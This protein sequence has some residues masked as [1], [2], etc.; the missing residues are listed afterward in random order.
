MMYDDHLSYADYLIAQIDEI[1]IEASLWRH[2]GEMG[3]DD[4]REA[5]RRI[6]RLKIAGTYD[7][8]RKRL[9]DLVPSTGIAQPSQKWLQYAERASQVWENFKAGLNSPDP[10]QQKRFRAL[11]ETESMGEKSLGEVVHI[12]SVLEPARRR[13]KRPNAIPP[14]RNVFE[15]LDTMRLE[16]AS[17]ETIAQAARSVA[18]TGGSDLEN[19]RA[20]YLA[21]LYSDRVALRG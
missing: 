14:W 8:E 19:H 7:N 18:A 6:D 13:G 4:E 16:I 1:E 21:R 9:A 12:L 10:D 15:Q 20:D 5:L 11:Y 2:P 17:G 3:S